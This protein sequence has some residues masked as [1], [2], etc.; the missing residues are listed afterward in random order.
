MGIFRSSRL[1]ILINGSPEGY[2]GC[3]FSVRQGDPL[4]PLLFCFTEDF[5]NR[6]LVQA[7]DLHFLFPMHALGRIKCPS[8]LLYADDILIF[9]KATSSNI[10]KIVSIFEDYSAILGQYVN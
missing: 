10:Y 6:W 1:S 5:L 8:H 9:Y 2:L 3:S 7:W 4:F